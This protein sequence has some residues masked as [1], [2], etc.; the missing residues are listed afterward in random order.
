MFYATI[1]TM[2]SRYCQGIVE[3][4]HQSQTR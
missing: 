4:S 2:M 3:V 1:F